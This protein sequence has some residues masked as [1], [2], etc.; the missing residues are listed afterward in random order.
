MLFKWMC[1]C[2]AVVMWILLYWLRLMEMEIVFND[3]SHKGKSI[4]GSSGKFWI[5]IWLWKLFVALLRRPSGPSCSVVSFKRS[6]EDA[7]NN[8]IYFGTSLFGKQ[9]ETN[10]HL[11]PVM[12]S[13][14]KYQDSFCV[15]VSCQV[16]ETF[17]QIYCS[18][19]GCRKKQL[20]LEATCCKH[21]VF[22]SLFRHSVHVQLCSNELHLKQII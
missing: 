5:Y 15:L 4:Y 8:S 12:T 6:S 1:V 13:L 16:M 18:C 19:T 21:R 2:Y 14:C 17:R 3:D 7:L 11:T 9:P 10:P 20:T 22:G